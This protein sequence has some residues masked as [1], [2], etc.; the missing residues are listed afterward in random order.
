MWFIM[1]LANRLKV[2]I[3]YILKNPELI[4]KAN[5]MMLKLIDYGWDEK[6]GG[7]FYF[8]DCKKGPT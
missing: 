6:Y 3:Y 8:L 4:V 7:I 1:D 2:K 5:D